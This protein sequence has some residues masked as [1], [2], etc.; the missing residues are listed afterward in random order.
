LKHGAAAAAERI[1]KSRQ[2][3]RITSPLVHSCTHKRST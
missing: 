2:E 3:S 1:S